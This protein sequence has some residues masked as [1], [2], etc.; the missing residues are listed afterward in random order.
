MKLIVWIYVYYSGDEK[1]CSIIFSNR[2][3]AHKLCSGC[4][5]ELRK[6]RN[7]V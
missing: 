4:S 3:L 7:A 5:C 1:D 6:Y 2:I